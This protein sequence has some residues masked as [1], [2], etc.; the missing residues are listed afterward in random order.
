M[1]KQ[2]RSDPSTSAGLWKEL[3]RRRVPH[4]VGAY[5]AG[6]WI[7]L[8]FTDWAVNRWLLSPHITDFVVTVWLLMIPAVALLAW[9]HGAPGRDR[10]TRLEI[11]GVSLN[12]LLAVGLLF[13]LFR[14]QDLG[15]A[16]QSVTVEDEEGRT[17][18][19]EIPKRE[20]TRRVAV[21]AFVAEPEDR[22]LAWLQ[23]GI[24]WSVVL[25]LEQDSWVRAVT[26]FGEELGGESWLEP[27][28]M[29]LARQREIARDRFLDY[30][31]VGS[32][33]GREGELE[34]TSRLYEAET[35]AL[36]AEHS[37]VGSDGLDLADRVAAQL[38]ED[39]DVPSGHIER[40]ADLPVRELL[41]D[42]PVAVHA[43]FQAQYM[44]N[45]DAAANL[46]LLA[47]ATGT[48]STFA[49]AQ[50]ALGEGY[51][52]FNQPAQ[53]YAAYETALRHEYRLSE[54]SRF[55]IKGRYFQITRQP[56]KALAVARLRTELYP[57]EPTAWD[58][59]G[60][61]L[62]DRGDTEGAV[63]AFENG[64][65]LDRSSW[66]RVQ[67]LA[68][69]YMNA[70]RPG[71][72]R[73]TYQAH[74]DRYPQRLAPIRALGD[75]HLQQGD[76]DGAAGQF[77]RALLV[78]PNDIE[79]LVALAGIA[80]R[81]AQFEQARAYYDQ[82]ISASGS[83][84]AMWSVGARLIG[85]FDLQGMTDSAIARLEALAGYLR[86]SQG[87][88]L[89]LQRRVDQIALYPRAGRPRRAYALL[90]TL[91]AELESPLTYFVP[92]AEALL[93]RELGDGPALEA[94]IP[95]ARL[96]Y[97]DF[98]MTAADWIMLYLDAEARRFQDRCEEAIPLYERSAANMRPDLLGSIDV[99]LGGNPWI[100]LG[101]CYR[102]TGRYGEAATALGQSY[103]RLPADGR[104]LYQLAL[105]YQAMG[106]RPE[107][108]RY[109]N[110]AVHV[111]RNADPDH[112]PAARAKATLAAW[113]GRG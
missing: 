93:Y 88:L 54:K 101:A 31:L 78:D 107:A 102:E 44:R 97:E 58:E 113:E 79:S 109:L 47:A 59:L 50:A 63:A 1:S 73:R 5:F 32:I 10:W 49:L 61:I 25:D 45:R 36:R 80:E 18:E 57:D 62:S 91:R 53:A 87:Q 43:Y 35:G 108:M 17:V 84:E 15:T 92:V 26:G 4:I 99:G 82:A 86:S 111:W 95:E 34:V 98:G 67:A 13:A 60:L 55:Q 65:S 51:L 104:V 103:S 8:E 39:L 75:L 33:G 24:P 14:G 94:T 3:M 30:L 9:T 83:N 77:E 70:G 112:A 72:A 69:S 74:G 27:A 42:S 68:G 20:F 71:D 64:H 21:F 81:T 23:F 105:L 110:G 38:R 46:R 12:L 85:F 66:G 106:D 56:D 29:P 76:F 52:A 40:T 7:L 6:G 37:F 22:E 19:R 48:D 16:T 90:D 96:L 2:G 100:G 41:S 11:V 89:E 28:H